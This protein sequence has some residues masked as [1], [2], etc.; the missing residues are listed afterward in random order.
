MELKQLGKVEPAREHLDIAFKRARKIADAQR[1][2]IT[3][4][5]GTLYK[6]RR[7]EL[8]RIREVERSLKDT[9][10][11]IIKNFPSFG[12]L[13]PFYRDLVNTTMD[14]D[15]VRNALGAIQWSVERIEKLTR[16]A[17]IDIKSTEVLERVNKRRGEYY[18]RISSVV[19]Q[20]DKSLIIVERAR[21]TFKNYPPIK[22]SMTTIIIAGMPNVGKTTLLKTLTGAQP[23]IASYPFTTQHLMLGYTEEYQFLDTPGLLD[24]PAKNDIEKRA[25]IAIK[26][27]PSLIIFLI[28]P[29]ESCGFNIQEQVNLKK[30]IEKNFNTPII[31]VA[32]KKDLSESED[33]ERLREKTT[34]DISINANDS[35]DVKQVLTMVREKVPIIEE[36]KDD[37]KD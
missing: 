22:T 2:K 24:R 25:L 30:N 23:K 21:K 15:T 26:H 20:I 6:S 17:V 8:E 11:R 32:T 36:L 29:T 27:L 19:K 4:K 3:I 10:G 37:V 18:G 9:L 1:P 34:I 35:Q 5:N 31:T 16:Q 7:I 33:V 13:P 28:D 12:Q 14:V